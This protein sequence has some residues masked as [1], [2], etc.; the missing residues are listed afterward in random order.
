MYQIEALV[1]DSDEMEKWSLYLTRQFKQLSLSRHL[2]IQA[3]STG[4]EP[5]TFAM[6]VQW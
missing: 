2:K 4:F 5:M 1:I 3:V 6:P